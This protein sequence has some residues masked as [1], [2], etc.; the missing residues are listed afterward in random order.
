MHALT[1]KS[2]SAFFLRKAVS[3]SFDL[4]FKYLNSDIFSLKSRIIGAIPDEFLMLR[5]KLPFLV[6]YYSDRIVHHIYYKV[7]ILYFQSSLLLPSYSCYQ[8]KH[9][10]DPAARVSRQINSFHEGISG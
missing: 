6:N 9:R 5:M 4:H 3:A 1:F 8:D 7:K 10:R 2:A